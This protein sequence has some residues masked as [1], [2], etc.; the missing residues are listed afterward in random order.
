[1]I[2]KGCNN[3]VPFHASVAVLEAIATDSLVWMPSIGFLG[4]V[5]VRLRGFQVL[6]RKISQLFRVIYLQAL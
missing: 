1:M 5:K 3:N 6:S 4:A 2:S